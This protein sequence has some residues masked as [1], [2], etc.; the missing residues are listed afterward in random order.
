MAEKYFPGS[1][2]LIIQIKRNFERKRLKGGLQKAIYNALLSTIPPAFEVV[3]A[4]R[5]KVLEIPSPHAEPFK[6]CNIKHFAAKLKTVYSKLPYGVPMIMLRTWS[7]GWFTTHRTL[8]EATGG[9][10]LPCIYGCGGPDSLVHY[11]SCEHMWTLISSCTNS[12]A[13]SL[14]TPLAQ[15]ICIVNP[16]RHDISRCVVAFNTYHALRNNHSHDIDDAVSSSDFTDLLL[17][18]CEIMRYFAGELLM[19][20][21]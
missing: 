21:S 15:R 8:H 2:A 19:L 10:R 13:C 17:I 20:P 9:S 18:A 11:F 6:I 4:R 14:T 5:F 16:N 12:P 3:F 7:N 1:K